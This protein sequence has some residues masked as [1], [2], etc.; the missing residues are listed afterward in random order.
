VAVPDAR[1]PLGDTDGYLDLEESLK[2]HAYDLSIEQGRVVPPAEAARHWYDHIYPAAVG[3][4]LNSGIGR[5]LSTSTEAE[6]FLM[7]RSG[8]H[9]PLD[10]GWQVPPAFVEYS[11]G[12]LRESEPKGIASALSRVGRRRR[13]RPDVLPKGDIGPSGD[14]DELDR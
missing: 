6:L 8:S 1:F 10:P 11:V 12:R 14:V 4:A 5:L 13:P 9:G 7:V 2:A 3:I